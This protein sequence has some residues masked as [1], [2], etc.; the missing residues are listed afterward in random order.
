M[1]VVF[2]LQDTRTLY[3]AEQATIRLIAGLTAAGVVVRVL[4]LRELRLGDGRSPLA[5]AFGRLVSV[6]TIPVEGRVSREAV[7]RIREVMAR[8]QADVLHSSGYK[9]D[10]HAVWAS[11]GDH[12]PV[13]STVH[14]WLFRWQLK[15]RLFQSLNIR[16]L[17]KC[18]RVIVL[19]N[20][21]ERYLRRRGFSP[22][23]LAHI[24]SGVRADDIATAAEAEKRWTTPGAV[25]TFGMLGRLSSEKNHL[26]LL[27]AAARLAREREHCPQ[28][29]RILV[30]GEGALS[31]RLQRQARRLGVADRV[32]WAS[33]MPSADFFRRVHVLVQCSRVENQPLS[34]L[35]A[36]AWK[37][38]VLA[39]RV[40]GLPELVVAGETG[41]LVGKTSVRQLAQAM[42]ECLISPDKAR[43]AGERGRERLAR[44]YPYSRMIEDHIGLYDA[45]RHSWR[46][47]RIPG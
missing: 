32:E 46:S 35:E 33:W 5:D 41:W 23:H 27:R 9:A 39:T 34:I 30:A 3:G 12:F 18:S 16:A 21:Y 37:R 45:E 17:R 6:E 7:R 14:G 44:D 40:G 24:P 11:H 19:C 42:R 28:S 29:W 31:G 15:E 4:L 1:K 20:F 8:E 36:M 10:W 47:A 38:P 2:L 43:A 25:F 26:L 22:L 13:V